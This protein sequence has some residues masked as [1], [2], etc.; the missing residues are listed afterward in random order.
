MLF[1]SR[2]TRNLF[3]TGKGG[4]GKTTIS[5]AAAIH[6][7]DRGEKVLLVCTDPASNLDDV[8]E[9]QVGSVPAPVPGVENLQALNIDPEEAARQYREKVIGPYRGVL[10]ESALTS[11]EEQ[12]SGACTTEIAA[13]D[14]FA[15]LLGSKDISGQ[16]DRIIFD[17][18]PTGHTLRLL[19][20]P[21]AW[22]GF[23]E[24]N[25]SGTSCLGPL[26]GLDAQHQVYKN[27]IQF[28]QD[29][30]TSTLVLVCRPDE[31]SLSE[32]AR[33]SAELAELGI[34]NQQVAINGIFHAEPDDD[35]TARSLSAQH[36]KALAACPDA[37]RKLP[38]SE[39]PLLSFA[40]L[41]IDKLRQVF[42]DTPAP[43]TS[44]QD[45]ANSA[46]LPPDFQEL[47]KNLAAG[48]SGVIM[49]MGKGGVGKTTLATKVAL[50]L[51]AEGHKVHLATTD[52]AAHLDFSLGEKNSRLQV[53]RIDPAE[54]VKN[55][56]AKVLQEA[57]SQL[58]DNGRR[59]LEE[60]LRSPCT[61]EIAVFRAFARLVDQGSKQFV[62][63]DTAPTGHTLLLLDAAQSYHREVAKKTGQ[64][65]DSINQLL[66][67]LRDDS[68]TKIIIVTLAETT[69]VQEALLLADDLK[70]ANIKPFAWVINQSL[71]PLSIVNPLLA[72]KQA[73]EYSQVEKVLALSAPQPVFLEAWQPTGGSSPI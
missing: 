22:D 19:Q 30:E 72:K 40:P 34:N 48:N 60:D 20:L 59:L 50:Y 73:Q 45:P 52:P 32:A 10:P 6:F 13:F 63:L 71:L 42:A 12:L 57:G 37:L 14:E 1:L 54:E 56:T 38:K 25:T 55:Y 16:F 65:P 67:R 29:R 35:P 61:E 46:T 8:L 7:A 70:R 33:T 23:I 2:A 62:V 5:C 18:A 51:A 41:G 49:T 26:S 43:V 31:A 11:M 69:P 17:T 39:L 27:A 68:F 47:C 4:V 53:S 28:L 44:T 21:S 64:L 24:S 66:P 15:R 36:K 9:T 3:F 58:D